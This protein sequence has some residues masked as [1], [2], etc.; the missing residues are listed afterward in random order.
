MLP[1]L[2][3]LEGRFY[4]QRRVYNCHLCSFTPTKTSELGRLYI[5]QSRFSREVNTKI[6]V[7][8]GSDAV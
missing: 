1:R 7:L 4:D 8:V 6:T 3:T 2:K 5:K